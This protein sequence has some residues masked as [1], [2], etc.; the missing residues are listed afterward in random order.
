VLTEKD[1]FAGGTQ[2][3]GD[4]ECCT[5]CKAAH[6]LTRFTVI[7]PFRRVDVRTSPNYLVRYKRRDVVILRPRN[8]TAFLNKN[9]ENLHVRSDGWMLVIWRRGKRSAFSPHHFLSL[10][11]TCY[12]LVCYFIYWSLYVSLFSLSGTYLF[13]LLATFFINISPVPLPFSS[14][15]TIF[16]VLFSCVSSSVPLKI[17]F[18]VF[19]AVF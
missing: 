3:S 5:R 11:V 17:C 6:C 14:L 8:S 10:P 16:R 7:P 12:F 4:A 18:I 2:A 15:I 19:P 1:V 9:S 13:D